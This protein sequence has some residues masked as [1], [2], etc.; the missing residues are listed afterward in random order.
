MA[1]LV[2]STVG[3]FVL[4]G[5]FS[6]V[7]QQELQESQASNIQT[8]HSFEVKENLNYLLF[9]PEG[10]QTKSENP[11]KSWPLMIFLHGAGERGSDLEQVKAWGPPKRVENEV[12]F[13]FVL[14][15][16]QCP[17]GQ[18]WNTDHLLQLVQATIETH[19]VDPDRV[20][21]T[22]LSMGGYGSWALAAE[23]PE[24]FSAVAPICGGGDP[25][26]ADQLKDLPIWVFHGD[27]D[28]VV[29]LSESKKM[30]D[31]VK[32]VGGENIKFTI[33]EG[34]GHDSWIQAY[35]D[36]ALYQWLLEQKRA[37]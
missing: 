29:P 15:S 21:L 13:P 33:Y 25:R 24:L 26:T 11:N 9:L 2:F 37:K 8:E 7:A 6:T 1:R 22:G 4:M 12:D 14:V 23:A 5:N 16:P 18:F 20:Y 30:V 28:G 35:D 31:A 27:D 17:R 36:D 19:N 3:F 34:V 32:E 10:Y